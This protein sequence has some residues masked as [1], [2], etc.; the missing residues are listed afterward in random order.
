VNK[1]KVAPFEQVQ[2][3]AIG[4]HQKKNV[5]HVTKILKVM[6]TTHF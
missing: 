3:F 6:K 2:L 4:T 5:F 1:L